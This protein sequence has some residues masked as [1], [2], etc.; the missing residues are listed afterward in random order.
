MEAIKTAYPEAPALPPVQSLILKGYDKSSVIEQKLKD[1]GFVDVSIHQFEF[2]LGL[3]SDRFG[4]AA[5]TLAA[6]A[7]SR[8][9]SKEDV[10]KYGTPPKMIGAMRDYLNKNYEGGVWD[11]KM[12]ANVVFG[13]KTR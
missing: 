2:A 9:W 8:I 3:D 10:E 12:P 7:T 5:G 1:S 4:E 6:F 13:K 11:G